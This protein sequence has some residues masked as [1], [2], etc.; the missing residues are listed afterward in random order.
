MSKFSAFQDELAVSGMDMHAS[1]LHGMLVGYLCAAKGATDEQRAAL[2]RNWLGASP[3]GELTKMLEGT[4][5]QSIEALGEYADFDFRLLMPADEEPIRDRVKAVGLWCS[6]FLS[7]YG[8]AGRHDHL[9]GDGAANVKEAL[10]DLAR[11]AAMTEE[12]PEGE[13]NEADLLEIEEFVRVSTL[14]IFAESQP[15]GAH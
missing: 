6:G 12:V 1:E 8:E 15:T 9:E 14:L 7:G 13:E 4:S 5:E 11:I 10:Q 3:S 2:Y